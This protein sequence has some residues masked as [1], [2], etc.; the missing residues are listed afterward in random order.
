MHQTYDQI[1]KYLGSLK[2][3]TEFRRHSIEK[4]VLGRGG[5]GYC[6]HRIALAPGISVGLVVKSIRSNPCDL[7][8]EVKV[9]DRI[10]KYRCSNIVEYFGFY[11]DAE[12]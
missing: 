6:A 1:A 5:E 10:K 11:D 2:N 4:R 12:P 8:H 3:H 7:P 9:L